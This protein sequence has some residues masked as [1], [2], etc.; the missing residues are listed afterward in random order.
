MVQRPATVKE[1]TGHGTETLLILL[2]SA[3]VEKDTQNGKK[4]KK[5]DIL[6]C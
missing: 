5:A 1:A 3:A 4:E 6:Y 2:N